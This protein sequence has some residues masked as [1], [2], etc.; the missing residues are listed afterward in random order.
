MTLAFWIEP[1]AEPIIH[2]LNQPDIAW[3]QGFWPGRL[4]P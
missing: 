4:G 1:G 2:F 3:K